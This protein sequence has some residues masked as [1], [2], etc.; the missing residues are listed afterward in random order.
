[1]AYETFL[2]EAERTGFRWFRAQALREWADAH[3]ARGESGDE[4]TAR[5]MLLEAQEEFDAM[6]APFYAAQ[7]KEILS[8][9]E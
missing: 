6:G 8:G 4:R 9:L 2:E 5:E 7:V 3:L 1:M